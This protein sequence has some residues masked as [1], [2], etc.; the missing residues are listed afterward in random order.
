M[1]VYKIESDNLKIIYAG[2]SSI[3]KS[4]YSRLILNQDYHKTRMDGIGFQEYRLCSAL[5]MLI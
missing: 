4:Y 3:K 2:Y 1:P 5:W